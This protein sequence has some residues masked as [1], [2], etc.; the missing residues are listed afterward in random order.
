MKLT[1]LSYALLCLYTPVA[2]A[3]ASGEAPMAVVVIDAARTP[4]PSESTMVAS[5]LNLTLTETPAS[6]EVISSTLIEARG[7]RT[8]DEALRGAAGITQGGNATSPSQTSSRGFTSGFVSYLYDGSRIAVPTM[9]A[10]TQDTFNLERI[11]VLKG[12][13]S[14]M[15]GDGAIGG[16]VNFVT[17]RPDPNRSGADAMLSYGSFG[18]WRAGAGVNQP[19]GAASAVRIDYS[20]QQSDGYV[21]RNAQR[22]DNLTMA[23]SSAVTRDVTL[24]LS[25]ALLRDDVS[26]YQ[27]TPLVPRSVAADRN[28]AVTD[29]AGRVVDRALAI[30]NFN[31]DDAVMKADSVW[32]RARLGWRISPGWQLRNE[33]SHYSAERQ[34][35]NAESYTFAAPAR[36]VRDLVGVTHDHQVIGNRLDVTHA[37]RL[38]G[39][40]H[41]FVAG[42]EYSKTSFATQRRFS[43]GSAAANNALT[44]DLRAP[45]AGSYAVFSSDAALYSGAGNRTNFDTSIPTFSVFAEDAIWLTSAWSIVTG[46]RQD[47]VKLR[48]DNLDLNTGVAT[49]FAQTY[50]PRSLRVGTVYALSDASALYAQHTSA[51]APVGSGNLLLLSA[52]NAAFELSKGRQSEIGI[53]QT[54][55]AGTLDYTLALYAVQLDNILSRD[56]G[57]TTLTVNNGRQSSRGVE[58]AAQWRPARQVGISGNLA[59]LDAQFDHLIEAGQVSRAGKLPPNVAR[60]MANLWFDYSFGGLPLK[61]GAALHHTGRR[62]SNTA[63]SIAMNAFTTADL[64]A[65]WRLARGDVTLRVRNA[66]DALYAS[67]TGANPNSQVMLGAPRSVDVTFM[68]RF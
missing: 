39:R 12:P 43:N 29:A 65:S 30:R 22:Y 67:W 20:R 19:L 41:R 16:V 34:W 38:F 42:L 3:A 37:G 58:L 47:R 51:S 63:N 5:R 28:D 25:V 17:R 62:F 24:D 59:V 35:Q 54:L 56:T 64:Y 10:R 2:W 26:A 14:V 48:R 40:K 44:L 66:G 55:L 68:A 8:F 60:R 46:L 13:S 52:A 4:P 1:K 7:A 6:V 31:V 23:F 45:L 33:L 9:S 36:L 18:T 21:E 61:A 15:A 57:V 27:G 49:S 53:K 50:D 32:T 11:E